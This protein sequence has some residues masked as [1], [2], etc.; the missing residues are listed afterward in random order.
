MQLLPPR[1]HNPSLLKMEF[2]IGVKEVISVYF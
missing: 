2:V 1:K